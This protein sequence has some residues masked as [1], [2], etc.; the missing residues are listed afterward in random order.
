MWRVQLFN[1]TGRV[2]KR[3]SVVK[4]DNQRRTF[5]DL[6]RQILILCQACYY[7][8]SYFICVKFDKTSF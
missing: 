1:Y 5:R 7:K 3:R 2:E 8:Q 6:V 4:V